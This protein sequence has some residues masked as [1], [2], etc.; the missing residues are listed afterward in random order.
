[1]A[2]SFSI[3]PNSPDSHQVYS[4]W[5][6]AV[7]RFKVRDSYNHD[8]NNPG[9][10]PGV[11]AD[12]TEEEPELLIIDSDCLSWGTSSSKAAH[13]SNLQMNLLHGEIDYVAAIAP[14]DWILFWA[15]N[16][17]N[18]YNSV[19]TRLQSREACNGFN[20]GL[21]FVG[22]VD[23]VRKKKT[24]D[25]ASGKLVL[26]YAL[27]AN[28]FSEFDS[29]IYYNEMVTKSF[30]NVL[31]FMPDFGV[32]LNDFVL[33]GRT[34]PQTAIPSLLGVCLGIGP[35]DNTKG[36][37]PVSVSGVEVSEDLKRIAQAEG[38]IASP[39]RAYRVPLTVGVLLGR[40]ESQKLAGLTYSDILNQY[41]GIQ[42]YD[43][44]GFN[45]V[46]G[47]VKNN[48]Y[49]SPQDLDGDALPYPLDFNKRTIWSILGTY[50][51]SPINEMYTCLHVSPRGD[52][53]P[54]FICRQLPLSSREFITSGGLGTAFLDLPRW[55][56]ADGMI[57]DLD[58][59]R[60]NAA[61]F[62]YIYLTGS[63]NLGGDEMQNRVLGHARNPPITDDGDIMRAGLRM[64]DATVSGTIIETQFTNE[65]SPGRRWSHMMADILFGGHLKYSGTVLL[66]GVQEPISEGDN[67]LVDNVLY[68]IERVQHAGGIDD[69]GNRRFSTTLYLTNGI[70][71]ESEGLGRQVY[72]DMRTTTR[73]EGGDSTTLSLDSILSGNLNLTTSRF[74]LGT[75]EST[76]GSTEDRHAHTTKE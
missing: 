35:G 75:T 9:S 16:D 25:G 60:S 61:R 72:P 23:A 46:I 27:T 74:V 49:F 6:A 29:L 45:P 1:M 47:N 54:S 70:A 59:G 24:R 63:A 43:G 4:W 13:V 32:A 22:R 68:H 31:Q 38:L 57:R 42:R 15:F 18:T 53:L 30:A 34:H 36:F 62:N 11:T 3:E 33:S 26:M 58:V 8:F 64:F 40:R 66:E 14:D 19:K 67:C 55:E 52:V 76:V 7:V 5:L 48:I 17:V 56:I 21:K 10:K 39:N 44:S 50:L 41:I 12:P 28:G 2:Y 51:N 73:I 71:I 37:A 20:D 69:N 65:T